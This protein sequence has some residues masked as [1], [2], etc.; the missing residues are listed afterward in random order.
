M[1]KNIYKTSDDRY[2][3]TNNFNTAA[4]LFSK[5]FELAGVDKT[6]NPKRA[7]FVFPNSVELEIAVHEFNF[8]KDSSPE[9]LINAR[10]LFSAIKQL[11]NI[12]YQDVRS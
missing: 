1:D 12:L 9:I 7:E 4:F 3:R 10:L 6:A 11:K 5:G 2:F 8:A